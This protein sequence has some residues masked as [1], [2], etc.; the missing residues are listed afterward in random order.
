MVQ[1]FNG[2]YSNID[3]SQVYLSKLVEFTIPS[4]ENLNKVVEA[5]LSPL[6]VAS[7]P[8]ARR[9]HKLTYLLKEIMGLT[10]MKEDEE[11]QVVQSCIPVVREVGAGT[12]KVTVRAD[13][14]KALEL[15]D[16]LR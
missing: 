7:D 10:I 16:N 12:A 14:P 5:R 4:I 11:L 13:L 9:P 1:V 8:K 3:R 2:G 15:L 6:H